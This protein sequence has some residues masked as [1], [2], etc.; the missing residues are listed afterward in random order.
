MKRLSAK[1]IFLLY[2]ILFLIACQHSENITYPEGGYPYLKSSLPQD[3]SFYYFPLRNHVDRRDSISMLEG[4]IW[5]SAFQE[6]NLSLN[7]PKEDFFRFLYFGWPDDFAIISLS[8]NKIIIKEVIT[9]TAAQVKS[10][11]QKVASTFRAPDETILD[12]IERLHYELFGQQYNLSDPKFP[13]WR[14]KYFDSL[15]KVYP[16]LFDPSYYI[17][18][19]EKVFSKLQPFDYTIKE[20]KISE[21]QFKNII[22][23]INNSGFWKKPFYNEDCSVMDGE[24]IYI[25]A[26]TKQKYKSISFRLCPEDSLDLRKAYS[27]ALKYAGIEDGKLG[28]QD[29]VSRAVSIEKV[30]ARPMK[31]TELKEKAQ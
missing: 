26:I 19:K 8:K 14:K 12:S 11:M 27:L 2:W 13:S 10:G 31:L 25:E 29:K 28:R 18:L 4:K 23:L 3:S 9:D 6:P 24:S 20:V 7:P 1:T 21:T 5:Y 15:K 16:R 30:E 22:G 17:Q